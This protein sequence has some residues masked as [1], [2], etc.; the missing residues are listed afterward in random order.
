MPR[1]AALLLVLAHGGCL[2]Y[3]ADVDPIAPGQARLVTSPL[4]VHLDDGAVALFPDGASFG[5]DSVR[6][7]NALLVTFPDNTTEA[8][9]AVDARR[10][11][12]AEVYSTDIAA[13]K[14]VLVSVGAAAVA[15]VA[16]PVAAVAIFGSCPTVY[17]DSAG[18]GTPT[19]QAELFSNSI[20][21]LFEMRDRDVLSD[22]V[23]APDGTLRLEVRNEALETHYLDD[24]AVEAVAHGPDERAVPGE[25]GTA[26]VLSDERA[27][28]AAVDRTGRDV[29]ATLR[30]SDAEAYETADAVTEA[31]TEDDLTDTVTLVFPRPA[32]DSV[33][34]ALRF[35]S[36]L[37]TTVLLYE[38]ML[39]GQGARALDW[40]GQDMAS[41]GAVAEFG[42]YYLRR[43]GLRVEVEE[44]EGFREVGRVAEAGPVAWAERA[45]VVPVPEGDGPFRVRLRFVA[46]GWRLDRASLADVRTATPTRVP[47]DSVTDDAGQDW[48]EVTAPLAATDLDYATR[49]PGSVFHAMFRPPAAAP[50]R[51]QTF[52]VSSQ[53]HYIE[54]MRPDWLRRPDR[55]RFVPNDSTLV[56]AIGTW[57]RLRH[58]YEARFESSKLPVR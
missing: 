40:I 34:V 21:P 43:L 12:G 20:A 26:L 17:V 52:F 19:L 55:G 51:G 22:A 57:R 13:G 15:A 41:I 42:D 28:L 58:D 38:H 33:A 54:W 46:G 53:G 8:I 37:L 30:A 50:G 23:L 7:P 36:S 31:V 32:A 25:V 39:G 9:R 1:L 11:L 45:I 3:R 49:G 14:S 18:T 44:A 6:G 5:A 35:R 4:R 16:I 10:V 29:L 24:L 48:P 27:P 2:F 56:A 47:L